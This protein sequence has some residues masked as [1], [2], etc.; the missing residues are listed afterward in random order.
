MDDLGHCSNHR[1]FVITATYIFFTRFISLLTLGPVDFCYN[2]F[3][4]H[5]LLFLSHRTWDRA[6]MELERKSYSKYGIIMPYDLLKIKL[7]Q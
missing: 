5:A 2:V 1:V 7:I 3:I 4:I 6:P